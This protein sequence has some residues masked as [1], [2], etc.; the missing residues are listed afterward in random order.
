[1]D[2]QEIEVI[3]EPNGQVRVAVHGAKGTSC[4]DLTA[5]LEQA[6]GGDVESREMTAEALD[7]AKESVQDWQKQGF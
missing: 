3:I 4:L 5:E 1:M 2:V 7:T 6:L